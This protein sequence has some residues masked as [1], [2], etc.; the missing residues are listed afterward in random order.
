MKELVDAHQKAAVMV[1]NARPFYEPSIYEQILECLKTVNLEVLQ[2]ATADDRKY[3]LEWYRQ[4]N[5]NQANFLAAYG[6]VADMIRRRINGLAVLP[7]T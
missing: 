3:T 1:E 4:A 5:E 7:G 2:I 6:K